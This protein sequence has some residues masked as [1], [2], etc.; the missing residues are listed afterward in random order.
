VFEGTICVYN[1]EI[2][3]ETEEE[4]AALFCEDVLLEKVGERKVRVG[5]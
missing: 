2:Y 3:W 4:R 5:G 1:W